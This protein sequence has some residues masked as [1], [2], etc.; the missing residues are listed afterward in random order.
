MSAQILAPHPPLRGTA[1]SILN[2]QTAAIWS[3]SGRFWRQDATSNP[4]AASFAIADQCTSAR[5]YRADRLL[6]SLE[7]AD[8][9]CDDAPLTV[10]EFANYSGQQA[11]RRAA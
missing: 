3:A 5:L 1:A 11:A 9:P 7:A 6:R 10:A 4:V 8:Q 2:Q